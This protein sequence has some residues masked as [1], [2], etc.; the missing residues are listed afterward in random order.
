YRRGSVKPLDW[1]M[2]YRWRTNESNVLLAVRKDIGTRKQLR[3]AISESPVVKPQPVE[4]AVPAAPAAAERAAPST[5]ATTPATPSP[6]AP[7]V[8][9]AAPVQAE[10][11]ATPA[12]TAPPAP[13]A[14]IQAK[15]AL[16][17]DAAQQSTS[18]Q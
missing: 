18:S 7:L 13:P 9:P 10:A 2:G 12:E 6:S 15:P 17:T 3:P 16:P 11:V 4:A 1:G 5:T 14:E 8:M